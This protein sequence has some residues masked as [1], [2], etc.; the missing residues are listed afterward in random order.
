MTVGVVGENSLSVIDLSGATPVK[1]DYSVPVQVS[2]F[3]RSSADMPYAAVSAS[4]WAIGSPYG[5]VL[6]GATISRTPRYFGYGQ[7]T[8]VAG[9]TGHF[10]VATATGS[11]LYF[12][13]ATLAQ[14]GQLAFPTS[15]VVLSSDGTV[16]AAQGASQGFGFIPVQVYSLPSG[17]LQ[18]SW[19]A[20]PICTCP[21]P[22]VVTDIVL[23]GSG[24][25][26]GQTLHDINFNT[27]TQ[28]ASAPVG[29]SPIY[30]NTSDATL[31][32]GPK[33]IR[34]SPDGTLIAVSQGFPNPANSNGMPGTSLLLNGVLVTAFTGLPVGWLDNS[35]LVVNSYNDAN[36]P[37]P[38]NYSSCSIYGATG[39]PTGGACT[40]PTEVLQFQPVTSD[41]IYTPTGNHIISVSSGAVSWT[42]GDPSGAAGALAGSNVV[43]VSGINL[44]VQPY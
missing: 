36:S 44:L 31:Y 15:K 18:Y 3:G 33:P 6:D 38:V 9:G 37:A 43:F 26:L 22:P 24:T 28:E 10:A 42:S 32:T 14:E 21:S 12:N 29:G 11:V 13:T 17:N 41:T 40:L 19:P 30:T 4:Q 35:R 7:V 25:V 1:A 23:S 8:S 34:I 39:T 16:L 27:D 20:P 2:A 5:V